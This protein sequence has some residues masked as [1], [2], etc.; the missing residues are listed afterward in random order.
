M[1][2]NSKGESRVS[3]EKQVE[4]VVSK[5]KEK[6]EED[7]DEGEYEDDA[8]TRELCIKRIENGGIMD[9]EVIMRRIRQRKRVNKVRAALGTFLTSPFTTNKDKHKTE[10][11]GNNPSPVHQ[12]RWVD[13]AFAAL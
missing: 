6:E 12:N 4:E 5:R 13:D 11:N 7:D 2:S 1:F 8:V 9:K 3:K 10:G